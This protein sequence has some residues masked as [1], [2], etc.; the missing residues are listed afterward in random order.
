MRKSFG[1]LTIL[2]AFMALFL[3]LGSGIFAQLRFETEPLVIHTSNGERKFTVELALDPQQRQQGLMFR[4]T[5]APD[6]GMLF[7]FGGSRDVAMWM[8]NTDLPLDMLFID[9]TGQI[10]HIHEGAKP[11]DETIISSE[12]PVKF[13]LELNAGAVKTNGIKVGDKIRSKQIGNAP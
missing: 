6:A 4:K 5:M 3:F 10:T 2:S 8:K 1:F 11:Q 12:G 13:V 7:D 9:R